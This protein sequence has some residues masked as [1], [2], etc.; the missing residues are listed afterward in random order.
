M[1]FGQHHRRLIGLSSTVGE[2]A[3]LQTSR[4][5][6]G[7]LFRQIHGRFVNVKCGSVLDF[8]PLSFDGCVHLWIA[9]TNTYSEYS[10]KKIQIALALSIPKPH[11]FCP[12]HHQ[13]LL[14]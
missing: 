9:M 5:N 2:V 8:P 12:V 4:S 14:V 10:S 3:L 11:P 13:R 7:E 1:K 6:L